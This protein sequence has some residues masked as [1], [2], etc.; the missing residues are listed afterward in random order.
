MLNMAENISIQNKEE[1]RCPVLYIH[2]EQ[3]TSDLIAKS[4]VRNY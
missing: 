1:H 4:I 3:H 2:Y